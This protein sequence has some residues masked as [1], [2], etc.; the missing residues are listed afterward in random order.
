MMEGDL[1]IY[2]AG[3]GVSAYAYLEEAHIPRG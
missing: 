2:K 1:S 3:A